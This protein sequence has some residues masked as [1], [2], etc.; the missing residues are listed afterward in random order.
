M[1]WNDGILESWNKGEGKGQDVMLSKAKDL[2]DS[3]LRS[4]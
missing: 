1:R 3:S 4:E 2:C